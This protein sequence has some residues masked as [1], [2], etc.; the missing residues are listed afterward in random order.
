MTFEERGPAWCR[1][2]IN[3]TSVQVSLYLDCRV[4]GFNGKKLAVVLAVEGP[5]PK[6]VVDDPKS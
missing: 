3:I 1:K 5:G 4:N 6:L 2:E